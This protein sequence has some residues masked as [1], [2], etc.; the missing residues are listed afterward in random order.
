MIDT[1]LLIKETNKK[2]PFLLVL[3]TFLIIITL[4]LYHIEAYSSLKITGLVEN[5]EKTTISFSL[6]YNQVDVI[7]EYAKISYKNKE[8]KIEEIIF[9]EPYLDNNVPYQDIEIKTDLVCEER[10]INF[11]ILYNKQRITTKIK[12]IILEGE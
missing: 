2:H 7:T 1:Y 8:Y 4:I 6:P 3:C 10:I 11:K 5:N 9:K 12:H